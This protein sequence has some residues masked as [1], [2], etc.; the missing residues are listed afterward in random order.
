MPCAKDALSCV[1]S[2]YQIIRWNGKFAK[3]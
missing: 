1:L 2:Q 3:W